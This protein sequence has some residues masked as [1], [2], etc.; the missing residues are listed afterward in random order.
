MKVWIW[1]LI[2]VA[3]A[4][5]VFIIARKTAPC[6]GKRTPKEE[7]AAGT[8]QVPGNGNTGLDFKETKAATNEEVVKKFQQQVEV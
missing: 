4:A 8:K 2:I 7:V 6:C 3:V 1:I 5:I